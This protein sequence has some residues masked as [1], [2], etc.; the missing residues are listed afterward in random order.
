MG[1]PRRRICCL[2]GEVV[3]DVVSGVCVGRCGSLNFMADLPEVG[4]RFACCFQVARFQEQAELVTA[5]SERS[6]SQQR[7]RDHV[8]IFKG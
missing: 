3:L 8:G 4:Q 1:Q 5:A 7:L 2:L 6:N